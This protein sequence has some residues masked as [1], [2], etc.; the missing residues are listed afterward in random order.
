MEPYVRRI[1]PRLL[2]AWV[3]LMSGR[4]RD[5]LVGREV[6][7]G[8]SLGM[9]I[10]LGSSATDGIAQWLGLANFAPIPHN[11]ALVGVSG[12]AL[13]LY[14]LCITMVAGPLLVMFELVLLLVFRML[15]G[16][17]WLALLIVVALLTVGSRTWYF[18][19]Q[20]AGATPIPTTV[21][22][23]LVHAVVIAVCLLRFGLVCAISA[24][25]GSN[26]VGWMIGTLDL[27]DWYADP[28]LVVLAVLGALVAYG[29]WVALEGRPILK[30]ML[31]EPHP[32]G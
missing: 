13:Q 9:V 1:W 4:W 25:V 17:T 7:V 16:R 5:P 24:H 23:A 12:L 32:K 29:V 19:V 2:V 14:A 31:A 26:L 21:I 10:Y 3:R 11:Y 30:D 27:R 15:T 22:W 8:L 6:L 28:M 20:Y 18:G